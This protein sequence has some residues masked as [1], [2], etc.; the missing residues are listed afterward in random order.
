MLAPAEAVALFEA[1]L[2]GFAAIGDAV[3]VAKTRWWLGQK[4][5]ALD[6]RAEA[7]THLDAALAEMRARGMVYDER[8]S[9]RPS[10]TRPKPGTAAPYHEQALTVFRTYG[11]TAD[12]QR[13]AAKLAP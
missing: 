3:N 9:W 2:T 7:R 6:R 13:V 10:A 4:L 8:G 12:E 1:V 11:F 5:V